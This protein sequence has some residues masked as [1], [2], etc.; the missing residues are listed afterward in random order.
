MENLKLEKDESKE[1]EREEVKQ[2]AF[3]PKQNESLIRAL[4]L[5]SMDKR[6]KFSNPIRD[7]C[8]LLSNRLI[9][10][11]ISLNCQISQSRSLFNTFI[12]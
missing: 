6:L 7:Y 12:G 9:H 5:V 10:Y 8:H 11:L 2:I 3:D 1:P 4:H